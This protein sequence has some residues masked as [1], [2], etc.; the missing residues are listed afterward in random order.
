MNPAGEPGGRTIFLTTALHGHVHALMLLFPA[1]QALMAAEYGKSPAQMG[2][3]GTVSYLAFGLGALPAG[4]LSDRLGPHRLLEATLV[5]SFAAALL[6]SL[7]SSFLLL[8][9]G[10]FLLGLACSLYHP[11]G[12]GLMSRAPRRGRALAVHGVGGNLGL[13]LAPGLAGGVAAL[14]GGSWRAPYVLA[15][16]WSL[17]LLAGF[18]WLDRG[19]A[20]GR[21]VRGGGAW[22][23]GVGHPLALAVAL[24][25]MAALG[26]CYR[27][28]LTFLPQILGGRLAPSL[29]GAT[30]VAVGGW[31]T[32]MALLVGVAG[33]WIGGGVLFHRVRLEPLFGLLLL[34]CL[35][36]LLLLARA[37]GWWMAAGAGLFGF[38]FFAAQPVGNGLVA[39][40]TS[41]AW[42][43]TGYGVHFL[44]TFGVG[45]LGALTAGLALERWGGGGAFLAMLVP[46]AA[47]AAL[48][49]LLSLR[50]ETGKEADGEAAGDAGEEFPA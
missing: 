31:V 15:A 16:A 29:H 30:T 43:S 18:R 25:M 27:G 12:L 8:G 5:G 46:G 14:L 26:L 20:R 48:A 50:R 40:F 21:P 19:H 37:E 6:V 7:A 35:G 3:V 47:A 36:G 39:H 1:V 34:P 11:A 33:Q 22:T 32:T 24:V 9:T 38:F 44:M 4:L 42:R 13:A 2:L 49:G 45:S 28:T 10:L 17:V 23:G 41:E